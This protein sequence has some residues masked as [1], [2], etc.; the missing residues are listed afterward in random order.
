MEPTPR[1]R[2]TTPSTRAT[3]TGTTHA[4]IEQESIPLP[5]LTRKNPHHRTRHHTT[6]HQNPLNTL[7]HMSPLTPHTLIRDA[8]TSDAHACAAIYLPYVTNTCITFELTPPTTHQMALRIHTA[9]RDHAWIVLEDQG[10][11]IG[12]A[13]ADTF[14]ARAAY[15]WTCEVSVYLDREQR[16]SG[17]GRA[18]YSHLLPRLAERGMRTAVACMTLPNDASRKLHRSM[19]FTDVGTMRGVGYKHGAWHDVAFAHKNLTPHLVDPHHHEGR[20][21]LN[22]HPTPTSTTTPP[23]PLG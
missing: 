9:Q 14:R 21:S 4:R 22:A 16:G 17:N 5:T 23:S 6:A 13:Y 10:Q 2:S 7:L 15:R 12:Y 1:T 18:L 19:G 20:P 3:E 11:V 8:T